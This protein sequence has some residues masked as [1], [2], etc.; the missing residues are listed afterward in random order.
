MVEAADF[1]ISEIGCTGKI[2]SGCVSNKMLRQNE[3]FSVAVHVIN[4]KR[5]SLASSRANEIISVREN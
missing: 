1:N 5:S 4:A 3:F 2:S